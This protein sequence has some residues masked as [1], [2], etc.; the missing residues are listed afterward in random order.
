MPKD[1]ESKTSRSINHEMSEAVVNMHWFSG[2]WCFYLGHYEVWGSQACLY[3]F[4][5]KGFWVGLKTVVRTSTLWQ[6]LKVF[7]P[8]IFHG[9]TRSKTTFVKGAYILYNRSGSI[10][11]KK[12]SMCNLL[13]CVLNFGHESS[14]HGLLNF[15]CLMT[16]HGTFDTQL[17][18]VLAS[19]DH[20]YMQA[21]V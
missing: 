20:A 18:Q 3:T 7:L 8:P 21:T 4:I 16:N 5:R 14:C 2:W 6:T 9:Y 19:P 12:S 1:N 15:K 11:L 10:F 17:E 13:F